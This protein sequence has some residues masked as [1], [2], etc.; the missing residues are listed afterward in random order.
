MKA[1]SKL[2]FDALAG[3]VRIPTAR[4]IVSELDWYEEGN[5]KVLGVLLLDIHDQDYGYC[6]LGRDRKKRF[7]AVKTGSSFATVAEAR[8]EL[9]RSLV[10]CAKWKNEKFH[11]GDEKGEPLDFFTPVVKEEKMSESFKRVF[12]NEERPARGLLAEMMNWYE[13]VD[14]NFVQQFQSTGFDARLWEL[15]LYAL[16][17]ELGYT[18]NRDYAAPD[19]LCEGLPGK[20]FVEATTVNP[21]AVPPTE[22]EL[23]QKGYSENY[24]PI[25]FG[26][27]LFSKLQKKY[28]ELPHVEG[29]P[30]VFAVQDF[31]QPL[32]MTWSASA[33]VQYLYGIRQTLNIKDD[34]STEE[35]IERIDT[36]EWKGK[37]IP[38][39]FFRQPDT[40]HVSAVI[41]NPGGTVAKFDRMG[42]IAGFGDKNIEI[43]R[44]GLC[45]RESDVPEEFRQ[46]VSVPGYSESWVEGLSVYHNPNAVHPLPEHFIPGAAHFTMKDDSIV[47]VMPPFHPI[48]SITSILVPR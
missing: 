6:L 40:E 45:F 41:A 10:K 18:F 21:S 30:L 35:I 31:H 38:A 3:Y 8:R 2:R 44:R 13:D 47:G 16:F 20:F 37:K 26:S 15:Y 4:L 29:L 36:Y 27:A 11:Q 14:G 22:D 33:L 39:G 43:T 9:R 17:N 34:G 25:K 12:S 46:E 1:I 23:T 24:V 7:R 32:S 5:E 19:F 42:F 28:W 48:G